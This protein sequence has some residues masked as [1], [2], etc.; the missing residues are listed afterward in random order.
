M[1]NMKNV[2]N[3]ENPPKPKPSQGKKI[4]LTLLALTLALAIGFALYVSD[5]YK[6]EPIALAVANT[7]DLQ[8]IDNLTILKGTSDTGIIFYPGAKVEAIAYLPLL[9]KLQGQGFTCVLVEMPFHM[10]I[11]NTNG[12]DAVFS[13]GLEV[14]KW[15]MAGHSMGGGMASA[16][17]SKNPQKIEG[18]L[19]LG[20]YVYGDYPPSQSLTIYGSYNDN[21]EE[22][23]NYTQNIHIIQGGNHAKFGNYGIQKGDPEGDI[24]TEEQQDIAVT[25]ITQFITEAE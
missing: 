19:L 22:K 18:L 6:A 1:K 24:T 5:Y 2:E 16:Y 8:Q 12:A 9:E 23:I 13:L 10:A 7:G 15:Y 14:D 20:A 4:F 21:L 17:A 11:F 3:S 25:L